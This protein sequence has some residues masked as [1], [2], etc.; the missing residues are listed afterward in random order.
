M[1]KSREFKLWA[2]SDAH[3]GTDIKYGRHSLKEAITQ[4]ET[5]GSEGGTPFEWTIA[6][7]LG[8]FSGSQ[9]APNDEEGKL[10]VSQYNE[11]K[12]HPREH[13][14]D[15]IGNHD[16]T[17]HKE[18]LQWWF[19]KWIDPTGENTKYSRVNSN[20][21]P[22]PIEGTW[23]HYSFEVGNII[24]LMLADRNDLPPPI[25]RGSYGGYPAGAISEETFSWWRKK[26]KENPGKIIITCAHHMLKGT[27]VATGL[28]EGC[29]GE[30][31]GKFNDGA[32]QGSSF[33]YFVGNQPDSEKIES[34]LFEN[35]PAIDI[36]LGGHTHTN[37][38]DEINGRSH[39]EKKW[40][41]NFA[42][43]SALSRYHGKKNIPM[44]RLLT[45]TE[46]SK[47][48]KIQCYLHTSQYSDQGW[49]KPAEKV[50]TLRHPFRN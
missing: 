32:P 12:K 6:V 15:L 11:S 47:T 41:V 21:R 38:D 5:G 44:S 34:F 46:G 40:G 39:I 20:N 22:F 25:G 14:Y 17:T 1:Q 19:R 13:F 42:N 24:F 7:N 50:I 4:S 49:Y 18:K 33:I 9:I 31:H 48:V 37:P 16:A 45:F 28:N 8:D 36:W 10:V 30:Y 29:E 3:V 27:T 43:V 26:I 23:E 35:Q 2:I